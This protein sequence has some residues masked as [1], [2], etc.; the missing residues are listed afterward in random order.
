[1]WALFYR[2]DLRIIAHYLGTMILFMGA[3][4]AVPLVV[5]LVC[6]EW[7]VSVHYVVG[8]G[9]ALVAGALLRLAKIHTGHIERM[10]AI[11]ITGLL[12]ITGALFAAVPLWLSGHY[13]SFLDA[14]FEGV[15]GLTATGMTLVQDLDHMSMADNM[16]RFALQLLGGQG[17]LVIAMALGIFTQIGSSFYQAE[18]RNESILP[19][20]IKTARFIW[21]FSGTIVI[22]GTVV[23]A[24]AL[25]TMG[26]EPMRSLF[27][28]LWLT[29]GSYDTG[30]F[31]PQSTS[32]MYY[33]SWPLE[34]ITMVLMCLG[35]INFALYAQV[36][37]GN[38]RAFL[39]DIEVRTLG[40]WTLV[41]VAS[42]IAVLC[43]GA[44]L[45][46]MLSLLRRGLFTIIS[47][48]TNA[49]Y[50]V[51]TTNQITTMLSSGAF[52]LV[53]IAMSIGGSA[54]STAGGIKALRVGIIFKG[55]ILR[56]K[57]VLLPPSAQVTAKYHHIEKQ[58]LSNQLLSSALVI[59]AL[60]L[61]T[62]AVGALIGIA[63]GYE[64]IPAIF[65]SISATSNAGLSGGVA[66]PD[67]P[68]VLKVV[69]LVQMWMGRLEFLTLLALFTSLIV[70]IKPRHR[71]RP[72]QQHKGAK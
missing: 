17:V 62:Y 24:L 43:A 37:R 22:I 4:M 53:A 67:A 38:W 7:E 35:A 19:S 6:Q 8:I 66:T 29:I 48:T 68:V 71:A 34:V 3:V 57:Q 63:C 50:Q 23:L 1:M 12:W 28:G 13:G 44:Y 61:I 10:Q 5:S 9:L 26:M 20:V 27:H 32:I 54:G 58:L 36:H 45:T 65:D 60:Y 56:I 15:S 72:L 40:I 16:W 51:L 21:A 30:G 25:L 59:A 33:H 47:A 52:F 55:L 31:A 39:R 14:F 41:M 46:D 69:Y 11:A 2:N 18:G 70:S 64:A 49:G 42:F